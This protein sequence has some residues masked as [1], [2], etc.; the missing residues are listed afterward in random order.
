WVYASGSAWISFDDQ[1]Q[2]VI[3]ELWARD[4]ATWIHSQMFPGGPLFVDTTEMIITFGSYSYTIA[5]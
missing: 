5:R 1:T 3:E 2:K 4:Q